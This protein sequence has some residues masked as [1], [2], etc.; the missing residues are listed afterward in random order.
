MQKARKH[1]KHWEKLGGSWKRRGMI[2]RQMEGEEEEL[3]RSSHCW[4]ELKCS[5]N[6]NPSSR[7]F[8]SSSS[9]L[10]NTSPH[11][12]PLQLWQKNHSIVKESVCVAG[13]Q[14]VHLKREWQKGCCGEEEEEKQPDRDR[15]RVYKGG[16]AKQDTDRNTEREREN[17][18]RSNKIKQNFTKVCVCKFFNSRKKNSQKQLRSIDKHPNKNSNYI[19]FISI[20]KKQEQQHPPGEKPSPKEKLAR[21]KKIEGKNKKSAAGFRYSLT[22]KL[23]TKTWAEL[24][25]AFLRPTNDAGGETRGGEMWRMRRGSS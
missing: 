6:K 11:S 3:A 7:R 24:R 17:W 9:V 16:E 2:L 13:S 23:A 15:D 10:T 18:A 5:A 20:P 25:F 19:T 4:A 1:E 14:E 22:S 8:S 12:T 21:Q